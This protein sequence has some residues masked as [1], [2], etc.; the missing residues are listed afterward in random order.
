MKKLAVL[1][2]MAAISFQSGSAFAVDL[3][4]H[5]IAQQSQDVVAQVSGVVESQPFQLGEPIQQGQSLIILED[6]DF[7]L[8]VRRQQANLELVKADL[9]IKSSIYTRY[10]ELKAKKSLSQHELDIALADLQAAKA[11][12]KLAQIDLEKAT[13]NFTH[14]QINSE[15]NGYVVKR[16]VEQGSWVEK[17]NLLYSVADVN[18]IIVRLLASEHDLAELSVG[19]EL[20]LWSDVNPEIKVRA[21]IKRIGIN[22]DQ[23]LLAYPI[24]IEIPNEDS[25]IKPGMSLHASTLN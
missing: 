20:N 22:L 13:D 1:S 7:K 2:A 25:L 10:K 8:E 16:N 19:Q 4:G 9:K 5:A 23:G 24:D 17:G 6:S 3:I 12:V 14:T 18:N 11:R 15:I 21:N